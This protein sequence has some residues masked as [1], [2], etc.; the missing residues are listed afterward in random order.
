VKLVVV[1]APG[2][3]KTI[4]QYLG[5]SYQVLATYG[6]VRSLPS[7]SGSVRPEEDFALTWIPLTKAEKAV[8][9]ILKALEKATTLI[10]ATDL[11]REGE[12]ISWHLLQYLKE[13]KALRKDLVIERVTF[14]AIT[15]KAVLEALNHPRSVDMHL[16]EAY[17][18]RLS[19]DYLVGF[20]LSPVLWRKLPGSRSAGRV[21]SV[22]LRLVVEREQE[23]N[24][25]QIQ[26]YWSIHGTFGQEKPFQ[27][28]LSHFRGDKLDKLTVSTQEQAEQWTE[29]VSQ[30]PGYH[31]ADIQS[32]RVQ[33]HPAAPFITSTLQQEASRKLGLSPAR[34]MQVAQRLYEGIEIDG[35]TLGLI[36]YMRTDS[37]VIIPEVMTDLRAFIKSS[38]GSDYLSKD[39][40]QYKT[41][42]HSQEAH[43]AIRPTTLTLSPT[44]LKERLPKDVW[45]VYKLIWDRTVASQM[46]SA[47]LDQTT[48]F[49][50]SQDEQYRFR[51]SGSVLVFDGFLKL[52]EESKEE[53]SDSQL[54]KSIPKVD[55]QDR[56]PLTSAT[57][58]Q[59]FTQPPGRYS[60]ASLVKSLE[61]LG[62]G[63]PSTYARILEV[64][65][66]REYVVL[67][68]KRLFPKELGV[69]VTAFLCKFFSK[70]V[71]YHF[72]ADLE[73]QLDKV[74]EGQE[75]WKGLLNEF[76][77]PFSE[78][79]HQ[80]QSLKIAE[81]LEQI[82]EDVV[83]DSPSGCPRCQVGALTLRLSKMGPFL[84][85]SRYPECTYS[86]NL[87]GAEQEGPSVLGTH[88]NTGKEIFLKKGPYGWYVEHG[89][90]RSSLSSLFSPES[91]TF[92][93]AVWLV[94]LPVKIGQH[95][96]TGGDLFVGIG[97]FGPYIKYNNRFY[98]IKDKSPEGLTL[99]GAIEIIEKAPAPRKAKEEGEEAKAA[100]PRKA[101]VTL[102]QAKKPAPRK[103]KEEGGEA[104]AAAPRKAK[105]TLT[106]AKTKAPKK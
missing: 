45:G 47:Q 83:G 75:S 13:K 1:E 52:Y 53:E 79:V 41:K 38:W 25:F 49:V 104:K 2:K 81:V 85:C 72:T 42:V 105:V 63:R 69:V 15:K 62:I 30:A 103:A 61:E 65:Q 23:I 58:E 82:Q 27:A 94:S 93:Q 73:R 74:S 14:N 68:K 26:E 12:A 31:V 6:H 5:P 66:E 51:T 9:S 89:E 20:T 88:P 80:S 24:R 84:T 64:L 60:E 10:L 77:P 67:D 46:A 8:A 96:E 78:T 32:K 102:T 76:W 40:R 50:H 35:Q 44:D 16:V 18:A 98:S 101:K 86:G 91:L 71:D 17:L 106:Q 99:K 39:I 87:E 43:E 54:N 19:L 100:A 95:P 90:S 70:Y 56:L 97:R 33:R 21:Q 29:E 11:D 48:V 7:K 28:Q 57:P 36:T 34:T 22:A 4:S 37:P 59:H 92:E 3:I 55:V